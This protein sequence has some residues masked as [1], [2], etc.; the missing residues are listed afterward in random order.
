MWNNPC[1]KF[2]AAPELDD[3]LPEEAPGT[4]IATKMEAWHG[5]SLGSEEP[6]RS[7]S[8]KVGFPFLG[9][10]M[11]RALPFGPSIVAPEIESCQVGSFY[12]LSAPYLQ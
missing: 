10:L 1:P 4:K 9:A 3:A 11:I 12:R 6:K 2:V 8:H 7:F 5:H